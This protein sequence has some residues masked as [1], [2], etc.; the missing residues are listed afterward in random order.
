MKEQTEELKL[1]QSVKTEVKEQIA[2]RKVQVFSRLSNLVSLSKASVNCRTTA[3]SEVDALN[4]KTRVIKRNP[5]RYFPF[6][7]SIHSSQ[8]LQRYALPYTEFSKMGLHIVTNHDPDRTTR[9]LE[10]WKRKYSNELPGIAMR[11]FWEKTEFNNF[12]M[13]RID[14]KV[15]P[16]KLLTQHICAVFADVV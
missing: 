14:Y 15:P 4:V 6:L 7:N 8:K 11:W 5:V 16:R 9:Y 13:W 12:S 2:K 1:V 10:E 3:V